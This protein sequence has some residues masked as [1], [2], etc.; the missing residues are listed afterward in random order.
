MHVVDHMLADTLEDVPPDGERRWA[1]VGAEQRLACDG[2]SR[3]AD[4]DVQLVRPYDVLGGPVREV[5][6]VAVEEVRHRRRPRLGREGQEFCRKR[7]HIQTLRPQR[8]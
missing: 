3:V 1:L 5:R 7:R 4:R 2:R 8:V 6:E